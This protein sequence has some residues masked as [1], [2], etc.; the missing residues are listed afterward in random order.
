MSGS[1]PASAMFAQDK[2]FAAAMT[3][4]PRQGASTRFAIGSQIS[5]IMLCMAIEAAATDCAS[6]P[7]ASV[8]S[9]AAAMAD[10]EPP[11]A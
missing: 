11:S 1:N 7:P 5:P 10:A 6:V 3:F 9:A 8:T 4:L 2:A